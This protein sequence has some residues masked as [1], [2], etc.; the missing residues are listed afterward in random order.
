MKDFNFQ[1]FHH[2]IRP[3]AIFL[4]ESDNYICI[5][6]KP[7]NIENAVNR[8]GSSWKSLLPGAPFE[9]N[10]VDDTIN[11][12]YKS[13]LSLSR[14]LNILTVLIIFIAGV[15]LFGITQLMLQQR[16]KEIGIRKV[17]GAGFSDILFQLNKQF[18][19]WI[20]I[21]L[22]I[23]FPLSI[24]IMN[25]WLQNYAYRIRIPVWLF[26]VITAAAVL[27]TILI[28]GYRS[29]KTALQSPV[30]SLRNE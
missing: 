27:T 21:S 30:K 24:L 15:G 14:L 8:I 2:V 26:F 22:I 4:G 23:A 13:E 19:T 20:F 16:T 10:F 25:K 18:I 29:V 12:L 9:F 1:S 7:G 3:V 11:N 17:L 6:I 28:T 5:R